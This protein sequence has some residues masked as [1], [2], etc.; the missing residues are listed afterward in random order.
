LPEDLIVTVRVLLA[1][2]SIVAVSRQSR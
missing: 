1:A 2:R